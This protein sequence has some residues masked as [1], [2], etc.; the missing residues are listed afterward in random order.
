M[1]KKNIKLANHA[2]NGS[3]YHTNFAL[4]TKSTAMI[5]PNTSSFR[6]LI[7]CFAMGSLVS[8]SQ[9]PMFYRSNT[10]NVALL[11]EQGEAQFSASAGT[12][13]GNGHLSF[14]LTDHVG[15]QMN[16]SMLNKNRRGSGN[17]G[18]ER[19]IEAGLGFQSMLNESSHVELYGLYGSGVM[20]NFMFETFLFRITS[21][22][23]LKAQVNTRSLQGAY[24]YW[25]NRGSISVG[26][27]LRHVHFSQIEGNLI[28]EG[29]N[30]Q[31]FL[32]KNANQLYLEPSLTFRV[33]L[34]NLQISMQLLLSAN[35]RSRELYHPPASLSVGMHYFLR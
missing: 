28:R 19:N 23:T 20:Q 30:Q 10:H 9:P 18:F 13:G 24:T 33:G 7:L 26:S 35:L 27:R 1:Q 11:R 8:C 34:P 12:W 17:E 15:L 31:Q 3:G 2:E 21:S 16:A 29:I 14:A 4:K 22:G 25:K 6:I 32:H 5:K